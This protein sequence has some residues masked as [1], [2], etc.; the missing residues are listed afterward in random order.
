MKDALILASW[1][2]GAGLNYLTVT[3]NCCLVYLPDKQAIHM[4]DFFSL[5]WK[6][7]MFQRERV[8][9]MRTLS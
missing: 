4:W 1:S 2:E 9:S 5:Q 8:S 7:F 3:I 6:Y